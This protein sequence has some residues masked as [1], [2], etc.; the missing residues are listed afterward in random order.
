MTSSTTRSGL[1]RLNWRPTSP[2]SPP[3]STGAR[4]SL[5]PASARARVSRS[6]TSR[7][8]RAASGGEEAG[9]EEEAAASVQAVDRR[10]AGRAGDDVTAHA[11]VGPRPAPRIQVKGRRV[12]VGLVARRGGGQARRGVGRT[13]VAEGGAEEDASVGAEHLGEDVGAGPEVGR[14]KVLLGRRELLRRRAR[15]PA[16]DRDRAVPERLV[17]LV[18]LAELDEPDDA[19]R[20][21]EH[22]QEDEAAAEEGDP[23]PEREEPPQPLIPR[24]ARIRLRA[25]S[26][27]ASARPPPPASGGGSRCTRL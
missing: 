14:G 16:R 13:A 26:A 17:G 21:R 8:I 10:G 6:S 2:A 18:H 7:L 22:G 19:L 23:R 12:G 24:R 1:A 3:R 25:R 5:T 20:E 9:E 15:D 11:G 27:A 4:S